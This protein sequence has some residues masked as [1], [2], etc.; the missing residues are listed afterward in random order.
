MILM[1]NLGMN[2]TAPWCGW[3]KTTEM[4]LTLVI[5]CGIAVMAILRL[6]MAFN[7]H[8]PGFVSWVHR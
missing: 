1:M 4:A 3:V 7:Y 6:G 5:L 2:R 8:V